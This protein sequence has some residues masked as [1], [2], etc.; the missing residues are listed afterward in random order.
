MVASFQILIYQFEASQHGSSVGMNSDTAHEATAGRTSRTFYFWPERNCTEERR[1]R[2][3][4]GGAVIIPRM[5]SDQRGRETQSPPPLLHLPA[6]P[7]LFQ[8]HSTSF[9][10]LFLPTS[11][12][13]R[14]GTGTG[15]KGG[16]K[17][18]GAAWRSLS[19]LISSPSPACQARGGR[20]IQRDRDPREFRRML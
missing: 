16:R 3:I 10:V 20:C 18:G 14:G 12:Q 17:E 11:L 7:L 13:V 19:N 9:A 15:R 6:G 4:L 8:R 5:R 2:S 1:H